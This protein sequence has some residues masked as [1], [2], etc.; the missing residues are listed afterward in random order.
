[1]SNDDTYKAFASRPH[2]VIVG[3]GATID[4]ITNG[5]KNGQRS[6]VMKGFIDKL[7]FTGILADSGI[8]FDSDNLED[9]Y[10]TL[11]ERNDCTY[12]R[13]KLET[14]IFNYFSSLEI[15]DTITKYD[16]LIL[17][18]TRKDCIATFNWD[19]LLVDAYRRML[20]I[21]DNLPQMLFLHGNVKVGYCT[22]CG[23]YGHHTY[24][25]PRCH[26]PFAQSKLLFPIRHKNYNN[27][28]FIKTRYIRRISIQ[29]SDS[30]N[31]RLQCTQNRCRSNR[32]IEKRFY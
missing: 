31:L 21:T 29:C 4:S 30:H 24:C 7:G 14:E 27:N 20:N 1:M 12:V 10:S 3:A 9:I 17:S 16:L 26:T 11:A 6:A 22:K 32:I 5:D 2:L 23:N 28:P 15:P 19:G 25:C 13:E 18:L 8:Q